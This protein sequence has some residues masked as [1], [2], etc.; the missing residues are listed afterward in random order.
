MATF[1]YEL[2]VI[3]LEKEKI[4]AIA[5]IMSLLNDSEN[6]ENIGRKK[7]ESWTQDHRRM[8]M[9]MQSLMNNRSSRSP[10]R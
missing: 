7:G 10:W 5:A 8:N 3:V 1:L 6:I 4:A 9:G 2:V